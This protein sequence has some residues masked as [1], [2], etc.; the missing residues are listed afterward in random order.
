MKQV[1]FLYREGK[2]RE[3]RKRDKERHG[4]ERIREITRG[5]I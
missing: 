4:E 2:E 1:Y 3:D 5:E